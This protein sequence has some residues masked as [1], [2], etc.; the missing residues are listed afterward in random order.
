MAYDVDQY[1]V[2]PMVD[3]MIDLLRV[4]LVANTILTQD[5]HVGDTVLHVDNSVRYQKFDY[6]I[7]MD[8]SSSRNDLTGLFDGAEIHRV[9]KEFEETSLLHLAE[10]LQKEFLVS[11]D[12]RI[13]KA[14]KKVILYE[15]D[16]LYGDRQVITFESIAICVEP[17]SKSQ[18]WLAIRLL[19]NDVKMSIM[20][21]VKCAGQGEQEEYAMRTCNAYADAINRLLL[22]NIHLDI[23]LDVTPLVQDARAGDTGVYIDCDLISEWGPG[24]ECF[25]YEVEDNH[26]ANQLL[27]VVNIGESSSSSSSMSSVTVQA[28]SS[29]SS[30]SLSSGSSALSSLSLSSGSSESSSSSW[31][32]QSEVTGETSSISSES[33]T[34]DSLSSETSESTRGSPPGCWVQLD[35]P[36]TKNFLVK[37]KAV[38]RRKKRYTYDSRVDSIEY[39]TVQ[40]GSVLLKAARLS[41]FG[42][43]A[44]AFQYPQVGLGR[45]AP[46]TGNE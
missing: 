32:S 13:Q 20:V 28:N 44:Q 7:L 2:E 39:G 11:N 6:V 37:D 34:S 23:S 26:G 36:L 10:P 41:W 4:N 9:S 12:S 19:G 40:K 42:K 30:S 17:V 24:I 16:I 38:L 15:K 46:I 14:I 35:K 1:S 22:R 5:A 43:E 8:N 45:Q 33:A 3:G 31:S 18:E 21:Y 25:A 27:K 29:F